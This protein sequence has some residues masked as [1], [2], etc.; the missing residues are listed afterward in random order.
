MRLTCRRLLTPRRHVHPNPEWPG[1][2]R[3]HPGLA[4]EALAAAAAAVAAVAAAV[5][6]AAPAAP[7]VAR[8]NAAA[9]VA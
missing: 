7:A 5:A 6:P 1:L 2:V 9:R 4:V 3:T 8:R